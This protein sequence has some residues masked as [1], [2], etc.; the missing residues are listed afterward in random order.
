MGY[1]NRF[2]SENICVN[3]DISRKDYSF[4]QSRLSSGDSYLLNPVTG[5]VFSVREF[6]SRIIEGYVSLERDYFNEPVVD[7]VT[8]VSDADS[9]HD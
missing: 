1:R 8:E 5:K 7:D 9:G 2:R 3:L 6:M 4:L